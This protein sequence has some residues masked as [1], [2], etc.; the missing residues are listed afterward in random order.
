MVPT[1]KE[2]LELLWKHYT[3][4]VYRNMIKIMIDKK[5]V[6][7]RMRHL[8]VVVARNYSREVKAYGPVWKKRDTS[9]QKEERFIIYR[10]NSFILNPGEEQLFEMIKK[11]CEAP[12]TI[13]HKGKMGL[14]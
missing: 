2:L 5:N 14:I 13:Y 3:H 12:S 9:N 4:P 8:A 11:T 1:K 10:I 7:F 6:E